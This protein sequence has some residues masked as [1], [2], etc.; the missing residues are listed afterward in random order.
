MVELVAVWKPYYELCDATV[1]AE[2]K[3]IAEVVDKATELARHAI[4]G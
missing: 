4:V 2:A 3:T 1:S